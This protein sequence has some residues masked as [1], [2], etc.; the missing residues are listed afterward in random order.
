MEYIERS[1]RNTFV[2]EDMTHFQISVKDTDLDIGVLRECYS[3]ELVEAV[4]KITTELRNELE[5]YI[6]SDP[7]FKSA[8]VPHRI[9]ST[10]PPIPVEMAKAAELANVGPMAAVAGAFSEYVG[11]ELL[12]YS[13]EVI[14]ENGGDLYIH[15][16]K[17]RY[18]GIFAGGSP[19]TNKIAVEVLPELGPV[20]LCT[21][22]GTVGPS[23]SFGKADA[24]V[25]MANTGAL[26]DA[27]ATA[28]GNMIHTPED[29]N[30]GVEFA[31]NIPGVLGAIA[32]KD[33]KM[34]LWGKTKIVPLNQFTVYS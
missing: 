20:G 32:I 25:V 11:R 10:A 27:V 4:R 26:A 3:N 13:P 1:Y 17:K 8:L 9:Y 30:K 33:D 31:A 2:S 18:V 6:E 28:V 19:F 21:S 23:L 12:K 15:S 5:A 34:A 29:V 22:S 24:A 14:I 16:A 7:E